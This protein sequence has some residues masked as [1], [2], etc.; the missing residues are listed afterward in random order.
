MLRDEKPAEGLAERARGIMREI[1]GFAPIIERNLLLEDFC[2][3]R[4]WD[5]MQFHAGPCRYLAGV[6]LE[7]AERQVLP[8][9]CDTSWQE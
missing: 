9:L 5:I 8:S 7:I 2:H 4:S 3:Q 6:R 1:D